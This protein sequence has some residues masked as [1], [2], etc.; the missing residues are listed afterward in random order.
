MLRRAFPNLHS[1][2]LR[3]SWLISVMSAVGDV[4]GTDVQ[5]IVVPYVSLTS[6][7]IDPIKPIF[8]TSIRMQE[9]QLWANG[10]FQ[11]IFILYKLFEIAG[12]CPFL[13]VDDN[14]KHKESKLFEK[15][16]TI[17]A[18][19]WAAKPFRLYAY[20]EMGMSCGTQIRQLF[21][22]SG[23]R[24]FK[25]YLG[26][27]LNIDI[28]IP[29]FSPGTNFC[30]HM[31][32]DIDT[33]LV[34][35]HYDFHQEYAA[36]INKVYPS[37]LVTPYV[38]EPFFVQ[39]LADTYKHRGCPPYSFTIIEP[40]ISFQKSSLIPIMIIEAYYRRSPEKVHEIAV[41]NG[42]KLLESQYFKMTILPTLDVYK[43]G[44]LHLLGRADTRTLAK[45]M[46]NHILIQ[47][48]VNNEYNYIFFEHMLMGFPVIH[49]FPRFKDYGYYYEGD[50]IAGGLGQIDSIAQNHGTRG[51]TYKALIK[52]L[53]WNFSI[54]N[55]TNIKGWVD[56]IEGV[57][58]PA[59]E[60]EVKKDVDIE[61]KVSEFVEAP[62]A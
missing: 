18:N 60:L 7:P 24:M 30:H 26:N 9:E 57:V 43:A 59:T 35:S 11:N 12:Y 3:L 55:P 61:L 40:N 50:D 42:A 49:N 23:A 46:N 37:V 16:R 21:K 6:V 48:T 51:E 38:W 45:A 29:M 17:D 33:I 52:Q 36:C 41:I 15:F 5:P 31:V 13:L 47:H 1:N 25:L 34:S 2:G 53:A 39:D 56:I 10:L 22:K 19:E 32:G 58:V 44:K 54:Y 8:L 62:Y 4:K 14:N 28:E 20:F 27:I